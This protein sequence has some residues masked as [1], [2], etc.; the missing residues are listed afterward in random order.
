MRPSGPSAAAVR[1][2]HRQR[3]HFAD[4]SY[5]AIGG[6]ILAPPSLIAIRHHPVVAGDH[7]DGASW[8]GLF[9]VLVLANGLDGIKPD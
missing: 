4:R 5:Q 1:G 3:P 2:T 9:V 7:G 6:W 8:A